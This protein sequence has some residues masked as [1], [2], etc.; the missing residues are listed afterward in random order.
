[1]ETSTQVAAP[2]KFMFGTSEVRTVYRGEDEFFFVASDVARIL[3]YGD[4]NRMIR[5]LDDDEVVFELITTK[6][7]NQ[8]AEHDVEVEAALITEPG[9]YQCI[10]N[11]KLDEAVAFRKWVKKEVLPSIRKHGAYVLGQ[12]VQSLRLQLADKDALLAKKD[13]EI[14]RKD[15]CIAEITRRNG[16]LFNDLYAFE[17]DSEF[18]K[19]ET[20][21]ARIN[22][23]IRQANYALANSADE[24]TN[25][26]FEMRDVF[27]EYSAAVYRLAM[28]RSLRG[29]SL[30]EATDACVN[31]GAV[32]TWKLNDVIEAIEKVPNRTIK[33]TK[34]DRILVTPRDGD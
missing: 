6:R 13:D 29:Q 1:M 28:L 24:L 10:F 23:R 34:D 32:L 18:V 12:E 7:T 14:A 11:S 8:Y 26:V 19:N 21:A 17:K 33:I 22:N 16:H 31:H 15:T 9:L 20:K 30:R 3:G 4:A 2:S 25:A 27:V 5:M